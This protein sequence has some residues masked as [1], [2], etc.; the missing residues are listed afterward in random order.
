MLL[1]FVDDSPSKGSADRP[2][3]GELQPIKLPEWKWDEITMDFV[4]GLPKTL[5]GYDVVWVIVD[6][7]R[8]Q[9]ASCQSK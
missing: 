1:A 9:L 8:N 5:E 2:P 3:T 6:R 4:V 7:L